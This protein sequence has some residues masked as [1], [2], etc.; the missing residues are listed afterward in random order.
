MRG[1]QQPIAQRKERPR[2]GAVLFFCALGELLGLR[3]AL[4]VAAAGKLLV[5][6]WLALAPVPA[7]LHT[8]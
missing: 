5:V 8:N 3:G 6:L 7:D 2:S 1:V 4:V